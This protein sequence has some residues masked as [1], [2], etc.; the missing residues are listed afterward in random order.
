M[1]KQ[2][3][4]FCSMQADAVKK[5]HRKLCVCTVDTDDVVIAMAM[6]NQINPDELWLAL[7]VGSNFHNI[8]VHEVLSGM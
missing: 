8:P 3:P 4:A 2:T 5:S 7:G 1:K 6:F